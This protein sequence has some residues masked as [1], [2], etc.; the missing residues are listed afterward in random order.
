LLA[1][2]IT[3]SSRAASSNSAAQGISRVLRNPEVDYC[4]H[5]TSATG[6]YPN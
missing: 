1:C 3:P 5:K 6:S 4:V 2:L